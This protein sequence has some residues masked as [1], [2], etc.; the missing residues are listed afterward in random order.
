MRVARRSGRGGP[1]PR[2][3]VSVGVESE[4]QIQVVC[5]DDG[6]AGAVEGPGGAELPDAQASRKLPVLDA[7]GAFGGVPLLLLDQRSRFAHEPGGVLDDDVV[8]AGDAP[9]AG[10]RMLI[11]A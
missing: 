2:S 7:I 10:P 11:N 1:D 9:P 5:L 3:E 6:V 8:R 4:H